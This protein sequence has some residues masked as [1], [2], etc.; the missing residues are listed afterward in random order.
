MSKQLFQSTYE[1]GFLHKFQTVPEGDHEAI[2]NFHEQC[3]DETELDSLFGKAVKE[4]TPVPEKCDDI[5][6]IDT[7]DE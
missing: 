4:L 2:R 5:A 1:N 6:G 3:A 7:D